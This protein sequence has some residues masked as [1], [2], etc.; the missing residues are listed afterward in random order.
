MK[1]YSY[2]YEYDSEYCYPNSNVLKNNLNITD[3]EALAAAERELT[4]LRLAVAKAEFIIGEFDLAHLQKI[5]QTIFGDIYDWAGEL[6]HVN[7]AKGNQFCLSQNLEAYALTI[8]DQLKNENYLI[9]AE[10]IPERLAYYL[11]EINVLHPFR[12]GNG[13]TQRLFIEYLAGISGYEVDFSD[14]SEKEMIIASADSFVCE[15]DKINEMFNRISTPISEDRQAE[16]ISMFFGESSEQ[17][18]LFCELHSDISDDF[19]ISM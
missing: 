7:I 12:E 19:S 9:G 4:S 11:S 3:K 1:D 8:F 17:Y 18:E 5:H 6:R 14:V 10:N 15:Y 16:Y 13:R 2:D